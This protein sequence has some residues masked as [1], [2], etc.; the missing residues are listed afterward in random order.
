MVALKDACQGM[1]VVDHLAAHNRVVESI[2]HPELN[3]E[4][5][6]IGTINVLRACLDAGVK[7]LIYTSTGGAILREQVPPVHE[8]MVPRRLPPYGAINIVGEPYLSV[9]WRSLAP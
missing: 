9:L 2:S 3:F 7:K 5:N 6:A 1:D 8:G 4:I